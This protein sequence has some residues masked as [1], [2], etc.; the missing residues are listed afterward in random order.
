MAEFLIVV[1][2]KA[3][4]VF[5]DGITGCFRIITGI[6]DI[7]LRRDNMYSHLKVQKHG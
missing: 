6:D 4:P 3:F 7:S 2:I 5:F 1:T